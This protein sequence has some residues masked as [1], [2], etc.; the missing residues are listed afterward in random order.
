MTDPTD[1]GG[2]PV[3]PLGW[4]GR[5]LDWEV[6]PDRRPMEAVLYDEDMCVAVVHARTRIG[7]ARKMRRERR[8]HS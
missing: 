5:A 2:N 3:V 7:L 8:K 6:Y 4:Q 1:R